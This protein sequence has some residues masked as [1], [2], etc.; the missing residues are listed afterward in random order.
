MKDLEEFKIV[1]LSENIIHQGIGGKLF[2]IE[3][4]GTFDYIIDYPLE[5][6]TIAMSNFLNRRM[7]LIVNDEYENIK[8]YYGHL[9]ETGLGYFISKDEIVEGE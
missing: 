4:E 5:E 7:D 9:L 3:K 1:K 2:R 8:I 6:M